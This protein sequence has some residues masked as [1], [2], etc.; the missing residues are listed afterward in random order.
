MNHKA[1]HGEQ[2]ANQVDTFAAQ[3][4]EAEKAGADEQDLADVE[5][6]A[7]NFAEAFATMRDA[8]K[9]VAGLL[10]RLFFWGGELGTSGLAWVLTSV[11]G[12]PHSRSRQLALSG[13]R[14][15]T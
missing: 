7:E 14:L 1:G 5:Q 11:L 10:R 12:R 4:D 9:R 3:S 15:V 6:I 8:K 2:L 13:R